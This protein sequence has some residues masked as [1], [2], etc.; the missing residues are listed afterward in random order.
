M[1]NSDLNKKRALR[2]KECRK[3]KNL[4]QSKLAE[5]CYCTPQ[6]I[7]YIE[8]GK[9]NMSL[10]L[11]YEFSKILGV[12]IEYL[13]C[14]T[15]FKTDHDRFIAEERCI[16]LMDN[17]IFSLLRFMGYKIRFEFDENE[18]FHMVSDLVLK[19]NGYGN[20]LLLTDKDNKEEFRVNN[21]N[22]LINNKKIT[23]VDFYDL[24]D[25]IKEY[26]EFL[27]EKLISS[28]SSPF[29]LHSEISESEKLSN[30]L[31]LDKQIELIKN[32]F[33]IGC[34]FFTK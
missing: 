9:R 21:V 2:L 19:S 15:E 23:L 6:T 32:D 26:A 34:T 16:D 4:T 29:E 31:S 7:S 18:K 27:T 24:V 3:S 14:E 30:N 8:T 12:D 1:K 20:S 33:G 28:S 10:N 22:V 5:L 13:M 25:Q 17:A 11:A